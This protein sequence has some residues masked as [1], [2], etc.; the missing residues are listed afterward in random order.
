[1]WLNDL[2][3]IGEVMPR[4]MNFHFLMWDK[5]FSSIYRLTPERLSLFPVVKKSLAFFLWRRCN[6]LFTIKQKKK[7]VNTAFALYRSE[8]KILWVYVS[9][10]AKLKTGVDLA[11][12]SSLKTFFQKWIWAPVVTSRKYEPLLRLGIGGKAKK[13]GSGNVIVIGEAKRQRLSPG[14]WKGKSVSENSGPV[15]VLMDLGH[16]G[17]LLSSHTLHVG[18]F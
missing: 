8:L 16:H 18:L 1:M 13:R 9:K 7:K 15:A 4:K 17:T 2:F 3:A 12:S 11:A 5:C 10:T 14:K 6:S